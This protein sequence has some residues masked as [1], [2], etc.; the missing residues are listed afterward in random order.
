MTKQKK[1]EQHESDLEFLKITNPL[2]MQTIA[3]R[4]A[5]Y[6][7]RL[8]LPGVTYESMQTYLTGVVQFGGDLAEFWMAFKDKQPAGFCCWMVLGPPNVGVAHCDQIHVW[9]D[10]RKISKGLIARFI[11]WAQEKRCPFIHGLLSTDKVA[12]HFTEI[13]KEYGIQTIRTEQVVLYGRK[14]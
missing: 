12:D 7:K 3:P 1:Q 6:V 13:G 5:E 9:E 2:W 8:D 14:V 10:D 4:V 11:S